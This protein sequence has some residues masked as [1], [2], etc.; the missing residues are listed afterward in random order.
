MLCLIAA[1]AR[2]RAI[3]RNGRLLWRL[4][5]DMR[6][7]RQLTSGKAV[8]MGRKTWESLPTAFRPLPN[9]RNIVVSRNLAYRA[10]GAML[11]NSLE[12]AIGLAGDAEDVFVI[13]GA[14]LYRQ[15]LPLAKRIYLTEIAANYPGD[16]FFPQVSP[17]EWREVSRAPGRPSTPEAHALS[18]EPPFDFVVY[19]RV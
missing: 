17:V 5:E 4:A 6:H 13:G 11:A 19:E 15:A 18:E 10:D 8:I 12:Q 3:G 7:F 1:A 14:E 2:N 16:V 9:R